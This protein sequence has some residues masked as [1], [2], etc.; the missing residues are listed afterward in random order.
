MAICRRDFGKCVAGGITG[1]LLGA[2]SRPKL[3]V[4]LVLEQ[5]R[6]DYLDIVRPQLAPA[7]F[8]K[9][10]EKG[11]VFHNCLHQASTFP[12]AGIATL[13]TGAWPAQHGIVADLW[14]DRAA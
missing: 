5:F 11:A 3:L 8:R 9:I 1:A 4:L 13:A 7:G 2:T 14:Y 12:S 10:L 6:P